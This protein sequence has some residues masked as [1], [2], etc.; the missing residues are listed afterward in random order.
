MSCVDSPPP[1]GTQGDQRG[2]SGTTRRAAPV[3]RQPSVRSRPFF[4]RLILMP[5]S[6]PSTRRLSRRLDMRLQSPR[7]HPG[8]HMCQKDRRS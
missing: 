3:F 2:S 7:P 6:R 4:G 1:F 8:S 5:I